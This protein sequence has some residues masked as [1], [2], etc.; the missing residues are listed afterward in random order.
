MIETK[1]ETGNTDKTL[2]RRGELSILLATRGRPEMLR[3]V[4]DSLQANTAQ[5]DK[6]VLWLYIDEDDRITHQAIENKFFPQTDFRVHWHVGQPPGGLGETHQTL[7]KVS[8]RASEIYMITADDARYDTPGWDDLVRRK[9]SEYPDGVLLAFPHDPMSADTSTYPLFGWNWLRTLQM[10]FPGYFP[11]WFDDKWVNQIGQLVG[12]C[13]KIPVVLYPIRGKGRTLRMRNVP[14]W[15][16]Y[17]QLT[18]PERQESARKL[19]KTIHGQNAAALT[20]A[21]AEMEH[22]AKVLNQ[23]REQ[24]SD[25]YCAFQ[26][27]RHTE[28]TAQQREEFNAKAC[29]TESRAVGRLICMAQDARTAGNY[30]EAMDCL[31]ATQLSDVHSCYAQKLKADCLRALGRGAEAEPLAAE[32]M[33]VWPPKHNLHRSFRF[34][35]MVLNDGKRMLVG[36]TEKGKRSAGSAESKLS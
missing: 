17:F 22:T 14:F 16:R 9:F 5:K 25:M 7:W 31:D 12:R 6:L 2:I 11:F 1:S 34:L 13:V 15:T 20:A 24:F 28:L 33:A 8:G 32:K 10:T 4:I 21:L 3:E 26:E 18:F 35:G 27:E 23:E 29:Q 36:F 19:L 30:H